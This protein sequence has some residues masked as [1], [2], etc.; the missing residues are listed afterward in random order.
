MTQAVYTTSAKAFHDSVGVC[1]HPTYFNTVHNREADIAKAIAALGIGHVRNSLMWSDNGGWNDA[2]WSRMAS[3]GQAGIRSSW[4]ADRCSIRNG[5]KVSLN[6]WLTKTSQLDPLA[7][8]AIEGTNEANMFCGGTG[9]EAAERAHV[10]AL[11]VAVRGSSDPR[12]HSLPV[13]GPSFAYGPQKAVGDLSAWITHGNLHP[14]MGGEPPTVSRI[15]PQMEAHR[16]NFGNRPYVATECGY[17]TA[18][19]QARNPDG[20]PKSGAQ[21]AVDERTQAVYTIRQLLQHWH[22]RIVRTYLYEAID[23]NA[24]PA[25]SESCFGLLRNDL[26][27]KPSA[28]AVKRLLAIVGN[29]APAAVKALVIGAEKQ[30]DDLQGLGFQRRGGSYALALWRQVSCWDR[31]KQQRIGVAPFATRFELPNATTV[32]AKWPMTGHEE[33]LT[34]TNHRVEFPLADEP[35]ILV[36]S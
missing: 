25:D 28:L 30:P 32:T 12:I 17:H 27:T 14:Y 3:W 20:S 7:P 4:G 11:Y 8:T 22:E 13:F 31:L 33:A 15:K 34:V 18:L 24:N 35:V 19:Q 29:S 36:I 10:Q 26:S 2:A 5:A 6:Q 16:I 23:L 9:W 1:T 21:A